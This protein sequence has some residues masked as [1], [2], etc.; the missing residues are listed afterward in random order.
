MEDSRL[1]TQAERL[2]HWLGER[3]VS[4]VA[5]KSESGPMVLREAVLNLTDK[6]ATEYAGAF[7]KAAQA[8]QAD[9]LFLIKAL[10]IAADQAPM[11]KEKLLEAVRPVVEDV[12][13]LR[14]L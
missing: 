6:P 14:E 3:G 11:G 1:A 7:Y 9:D 4:L 2:R 8:A 12:V 13:D 5:K 10:A